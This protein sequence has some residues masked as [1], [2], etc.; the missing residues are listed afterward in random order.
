MLG[1]VNGPKIKELGCIL[2]NDMLTANSS[3]PQP[4]VFRYQRRPLV[5]NHQLSWQPGF[6]QFCNRGDVSIHLKAFHAFSCIMLRVPTQVLSIILVGASSRVLCLKCTRN[7]SRW[8]SLLLF[9]SHRPGPTQLLSLTCLHTWDH[10]R[11]IVK[12]SLLRAYSRAGHC[13]QFHQ[14][15]STLTPRVGTSKRE[16]CQG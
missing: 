5:E 6:S 4:K 14:K 8:L 15:P 12:P 1:V 10:L 3:L 13:D 16:Q 9:K 2:R 7:F 11:W